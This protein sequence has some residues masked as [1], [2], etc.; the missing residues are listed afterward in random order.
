MTHQEIAD[1]T[2]YVRTA[3]SNAAPVIKRLASGRT[4]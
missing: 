3:C 4:S 2:A 1:I